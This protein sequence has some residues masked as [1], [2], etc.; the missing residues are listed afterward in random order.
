MRGST[1]F[2]VKEESREDKVP[3]LGVAGTARR[4]TVSLGDV[5][6]FKLTDKSRA[7]YLLEVRANNKYKLWHFVRFNWHRYVF[8]GIYFPAAVLVLI[9][10]GTLLGFVGFV[11]LCVGLLVSDLSWIRGRNKNRQFTRKTTNWDEVERIAN[12]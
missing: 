1:S 3:Q 4:A 12:S 8:F 10:W 11:G 5:T 2:N 6:M 9:Y 7:R